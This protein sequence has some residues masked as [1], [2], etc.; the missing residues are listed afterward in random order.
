V[1]TTTQLK[2]SDWVDLVIAEPVLLEASMYLSVTHYHLHNSGRTNS[3]MANEHK[4]NAIRLI[5]QKLSDLSGG[6]GDGVMSA[7]FTLAYCEVSV[8]FDI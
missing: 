7:V 1:D 3:A 6:L 2:A 5:N 8:A 4:G